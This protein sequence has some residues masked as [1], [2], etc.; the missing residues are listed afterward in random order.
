MC[1]V[2]CRDSILERDD[3]DM[4]DL[5]IFILSVSRVEL[6]CRLLW[7]LMWKGLWSGWRNVN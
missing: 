5:I 7:I 1:S 2:L 6:V 4:P 3:I